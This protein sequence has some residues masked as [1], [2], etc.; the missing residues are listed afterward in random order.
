M[1]VNISNFYLKNNFDKQL[2]LGCGWGLCS[3][4]RGSISVIDRW[5]G[6][7][8]STDLPLQ[9]RVILSYINLEAKGTNI[10]HQD[11]VFTNSI[12]LIYLSDL[13]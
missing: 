2:A 3:C 6:S 1:E 12:I 13:L 10:K 7:A 8:Y 4:R 9:L 11:Y 5:L